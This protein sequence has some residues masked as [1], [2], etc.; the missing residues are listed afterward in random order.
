MPTKRLPCI[1]GRGSCMKLRSA[2]SSVVAIIA[3]GHKSY[4]LN[5]LTGK[6]IKRVGG[7]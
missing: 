3:A 7:V 2:P 6:K 4:F 1:E 5:R